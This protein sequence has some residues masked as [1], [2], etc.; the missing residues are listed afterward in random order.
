MTSET[1]AEEVALTP[2]EALEKAIAEKE[3]EDEE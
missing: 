2:E 1:A 3:S